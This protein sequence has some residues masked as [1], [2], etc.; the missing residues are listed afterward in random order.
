MQ[1]GVKMLSTDNI[2]IQEVRLE[3]EQVE[4]K[5]ALDNDLVVLVVED[6]AFST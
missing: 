4:R 6:H 2:N 1:T 3:N 5:M